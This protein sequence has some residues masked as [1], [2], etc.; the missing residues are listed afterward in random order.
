[1]LFAHQRQLLGEPLRGFR[2]RHRR[3]HD[4]ENCGRAGRR[5]IVC[6]IYHTA[7]D[8]LRTTVPVGTSVAQ[9]FI[10]GNV[11]DSAR[12]CAQARVITA[13][14]IPRT[15]QVAQS[16]HVK[17]KATRS[18]KFFVMRGISEKQPVCQ[19]SEYS[20]LYQCRILAFIGLQRFEKLRQTIRK[21]RMRKQ[22]VLDAYVIGSVQCKIL[23]HRRYDASAP[24]EI[25]DHLLCTL[26][27]QPMLQRV[28][29]CCKF[30]W[31]EYRNECIYVHSE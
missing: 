2:V 9:A 11:L 29:S 4:E 19:S 25:F 16:Y 10:D 27:R 18:P 5:S 26:L 20:V 14:I 24:N 7:A 8:V 17:R 28:R 3:E 12:E 22:R 1:M 13:R 30:R 23:L 15:T 6:E 31:I 21:P